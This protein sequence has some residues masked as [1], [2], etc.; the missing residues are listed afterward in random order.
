[1]AISVQTSWHYWIAQR[2]LHSW[3]CQKTTIDPFS[4]DNIKIIP[5]CFRPFG[6]QRQC[7]PYLYILFSSFILYLQIGQLWMGLLRTKGSRIWPRN[8]TTVPFRDSCIVELLATFY[9]SWNLWTPLMAKN[10]PKG[11]PNWLNFMQFDTGCPCLQLTPSAWFYTLE[12]LCKI[13]LG[14]WSGQ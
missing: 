7:N 12:P 9:V 2:L 5:A 11:D 10:C 4:T 6:F 8:N 13:C 3:C 1:M 14:R